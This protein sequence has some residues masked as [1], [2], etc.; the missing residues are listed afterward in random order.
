[1]AEKQQTGKATS[2]AAQLR[3]EVEQQ[4]K[5]GTEAKALKAEIDGLKS[6]VQEKDRKATE[7]T[8]TIRRLEE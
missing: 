3:K 8:E 1:M 2:E 7:L 6:T 5:I 4:G